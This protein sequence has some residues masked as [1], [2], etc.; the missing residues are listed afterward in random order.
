VITGNAQTYWYLTRA[1][2]T[3]AL[4]TL[5]VA[6]VLGVLTSLRWR[7]R[8]WPRFVTNGL[9]RNV[10]LLAVAFVAVHVVTT[11]ADGYAPIGLKDAV[12]PFASRY[13]PVWLGL[14]AVAFDLLL[15]LVVTSL[16]RARL[17]Y[18]TW[19]VLHWLAYAIWPVA[20]IHALG[21]GSD[22]HAGWLR[23]VGFASLA[24]VVAAVLARLLLRGGGSPV[25][26]LAAAAA[27]ILAPLAIV[28]WYRSGPAQPGWAKRAGTPTSLLAGRHTLPVVER[29]AARRARLPRGP[30]SAS[31]RNGTIRESTE[32]SGLVT[33]VIAG[34][35][36]GGPGGAFRIDLRGEPTENG[37]AMA[38]SGVSFV[39][40]RAATVYSG[41]VTSLRG[42]RVDAVVS[43]GAG[44]RLH[45]GFALDIAATAGTVS[46]TVSGRSA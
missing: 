13:R 16:L 6:M 26:R 8:R 3:V 15:A 41:S 18:R 1:T 11:V 45:L 37:V 32:P 38:A 40:D 9:H 21:T 44:Q 5:T 20:L 39:P 17:G 28:V 2:G 24:L 25:V 33:V 23:A 7:N 19:R 34:T 29:V 27:A 31:L 30:F 12:L 10:T 43:N 14:G 46:G 22:A 36:H 35:L 42:Q 4:L